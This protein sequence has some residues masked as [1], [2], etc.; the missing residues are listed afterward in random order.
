MNEVV[1]VCTGNK[2]A[3]HRRR[4]ID[5]LELVDAEWCVVQP[6][7]GGDPGSRAAVPL[8]VLCARDGWPTPGI[9]PLNC[10]RCGRDTRPTPATLAKVL[11]V[12]AAADGNCLDLRHL[13][14]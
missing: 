11:D 14:F 3:E 13:P 6:D 7:R 12:V 9:Y 1:V 8:A 2:R 5:R 4:V 10:T